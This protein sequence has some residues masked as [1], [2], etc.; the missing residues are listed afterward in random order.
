MPVQLAVSVVAGIVSFVP[1]V[2]L[3]GGRKFLEDLRRMRP[4]S[5]GLDPELQSAIG[6]AQTLEGSR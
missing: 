2:V 4:K 3:V 6:P 1:V 5:V